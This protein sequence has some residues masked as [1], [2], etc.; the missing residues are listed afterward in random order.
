M[1]VHV[2]ADGSIVYAP[3]LPEYE[4]VEL[5]TTTNVSKAGTATITLPPGHPKYNDFISYKTVV[6]IYRDNVLLF[7]GRALYPED[8]FDNCRAITCE[9]ERAFFLDSVIRPYIYQDEPSVIFADLVAQHNSQVDASKQFQVGTITAVDPNN[10][11]RLESSKAEQTADVIDKLVERVGGYLVFTTNTSGQRVVNWYAELTY[12]SDQ[13]IEFG[14]N[15]LDFSRSGANTDLATVIVPYGAKD[16]ATGA[17]VTIADVNNGVDYIQD[18]E[19]VALRGA[20]T[21][22]VYWDDVTTSANLLKKAQ[23]YLNSSKMMVQSLSLSAVDLSVLDKSIDT[24][25]VGDLV[26]VTSKPHDVDEMFLLQERTYDLLNPANDTVTLGKETATLTGGDVIGDRNNRN[27]LLNTENEIRDDYIRDIEDAIE[28]ANVTTA[29]LIKQTSDSILME[30]SETYAT[31]D[32]IDS[33]VSTAMTQTA[34]EFEFKFS[35]LQ[36]IVDE[37]DAEA[38]ER[39]ESIE[40]YIRFVDGNIVLGEAGNELVLRIENDR[41]SFLDA[42]AEVAYFSNQKL[43]VTD[44]QFLHSLQIGQ[45]AFLPRRNGNLSLVKAAVD[46]VITEQ[47]EAPPSVLVGGNVTMSI[48]AT[49]RN[50]EYQWQRKIDT[51]T[52]G[53]ENIDGANNASYT[54]RFQRYTQKV[55]LPNGATNTVTLP[56][57]YRCRVSDI[58]GG[59][60]MSDEVA[61]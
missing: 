2:Y 45:F 59:F 11:I 28:E 18:S 57:Y 35:S 4:L 6:E 9:G 34:E 25:Q 43:Y 46:I 39:F 12:R 41:I 38:R 20:I 21:K 1:A 22:A 3:N 37:N 40:K 29:S 5:K 48:T 49:G 44:S 24:F 16:E 10:Y 26:R 14:S 19:A 36:A 17:R 51:I 54:H 60:V 31:N 15:L 13:A 7:R 58:T 33:K 23:Q 53:W 30:V 55:T 50:L 27:D 56:Q 42:G 61:L 52:D 8:D 32:S 47:P